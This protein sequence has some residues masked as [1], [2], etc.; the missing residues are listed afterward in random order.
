MPKN[1]VVC[2]DGTG[3]VYG[4]RNTNVGYLYE[5]IERGTPEQVVFYA[6]G[7]GTFGPFGWRFAKSLGKLLGSA[8]GYGLKQNLEQAYRFVM[9]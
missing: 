7:V 1:I 4:E 5:A 2:C 3:N 6:A 8:F 9:E